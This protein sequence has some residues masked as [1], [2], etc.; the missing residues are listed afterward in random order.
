MR[1][2]LR[3]AIPSVLLAFLFWNIVKDWRTV[4]QYWSNFAIAPVLISFVFLV[5]DYP[6]GALGWHIVLRKMGINISFRKSLRI[7]ILSTASRYVPGSIWQFIGRVELAQREGIARSK[8]IASLLLEIF[9][10]L[11]AGVFMS[12]LALPFI[13][14]NQLGIGLWIFLLPFPLLLLHPNIANRIIDLLARISKKDIR[15]V[16][17][18]FSSSDTI[19]AFPWF[20]VN[21]LINGTA[22]FFL[23]TALVGTIEPSWLIAYTG[24]YALSW[25]LG[26]VALFAPAGVGVTE[27]SLAYLLSFS[28]PFSLASTIA[29]SYRFFLTIAELL[30]FLFV[31]KIRK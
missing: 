8:T 17:V 26:Y 1:K 15:R 7:W 11:V 6:E 10:V 31:I 28:M 25:V 3:A 19:S 23:V 2:F 5:T 4:T 12:L 14:L 27:V 16:D 30:V 18:S 13:K 29:L 22:L 24:F 20:A 21:F 9:L